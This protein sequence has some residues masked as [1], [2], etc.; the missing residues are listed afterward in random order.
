MM[1]MVPFREEYI[2]GTKEIAEYPGNIARSAYKDDVWN[3]LQIPI[4]EKIRHLAV[5]WNM[6]G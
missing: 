4:W 6:F 1:V 5:M 2:R 3:R